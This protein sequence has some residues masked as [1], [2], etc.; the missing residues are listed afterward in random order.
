MEERPRS[1]HEIPR[2]HPFCDGAVIS[3]WEDVHPEVRAPARD[4]GRTQAQPE[5][6]VAGVARDSFGEIVAILDFD[7]Q[8]LLSVPEKPARRP[9]SVVPSQDCNCTRVESDC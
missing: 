8:G 7:S 1:C 6:L 5:R 3:K 2:E 4:D 9:Q